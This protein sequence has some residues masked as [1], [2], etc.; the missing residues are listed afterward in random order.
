MIMAMLFGAFVMCLG[1]HLAEWAQEG[2]A[3]SASDQLAAPW[4]RVILGVFAAGVFGS[5]AMD[6]VAARKLSRMAGA[7]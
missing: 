3:M 7:A 2:T 5:G 6:F 1:P 4:V